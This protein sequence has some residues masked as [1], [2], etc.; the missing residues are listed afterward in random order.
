MGGRQR[1][2]SSRAAGACKP[3]D[4]VITTAPDCQE[5]SEPSEEE[6][7]G[8]LNGYEPRDEIAFQKDMV[9]SFRVANIRLGEYIKTL[10]GKITPLQQPPIWPIALIGFI[11]SH[12]LHFIFARIRAMVPQQVQDA[13][14]AADAAETDLEAKAAVKLD[15][16]AKA[17]QADADQAASLTARDAAAKALQAAV[18]SWLGN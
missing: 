9:Q 1:P 12:I 16:D 2:C 15:L 7:G 10:E 3:L 6:H 17:I 11:V 14:L 4:A 5:W 13:L 18:Q 8:W